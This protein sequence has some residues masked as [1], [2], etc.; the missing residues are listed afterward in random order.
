MAAALQIN[1]ALWGMLICVSM[2]LGPVIQ[3]LY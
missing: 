3:T 2:K 1:F